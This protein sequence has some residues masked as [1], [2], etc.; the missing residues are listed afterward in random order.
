VQR[1]C[2]QCIIYNLSWEHG[3]KDPWCRLRYGGRAQGGGAAWRH[4]LSTARAMK[5]MRIFILKISLRFDGGEGLRSLCMVLAK[6][7]QDRMSTHA[8]FT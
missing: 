8:R 7:L 4:G 6:I 3:A 1:G 5:I 2:F